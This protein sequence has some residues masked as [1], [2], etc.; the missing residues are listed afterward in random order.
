MHLP[1]SAIHS[2]AFSFE[3]HISHIPS[4]ALLYPF[5]IFSASLCLI[6]HQNLP[7]HPQW[8]G[9]HYGNGGSLM[10]KTITKRHFDHNDRWKCGVISWLYGKCYGWFFG[11]VWALPITTAPFPLSAHIFIPCTH[12][13]PCTHSDCAHSPCIYSPCTHPSPCTKK[14]RRPWRRSLTS[15]HLEIAAC[16]RSRKVHYITAKLLQ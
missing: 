8:S 9:I 12:P 4:I 7:A 5:Y 2:S 3:C 13:A 6:L 11:F 15:L 16:L 10:G 1:T 14:D